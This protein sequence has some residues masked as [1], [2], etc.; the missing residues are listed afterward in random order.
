MRSATWVGPALVALL[1]AGS[2]QG[3]AQQLHLTLVASGLSSP[4]YVAATQSEPS[5]LYVVEKTGQIRVVDGGT[6]LPTPFL[7]VSALIATDDERGL[8][9]MAFSPSYGKNH[10]FYVYYTAANGDVEVVQYKSKHKQALPG[11]AHVVLEVPHP[12]S[13]HNGGQLQFGPDGQLYAGTGDGG[14]AGDPDDNAQNLSSKLGKLLRWN[15]KNG[16]WSLAGYGLRN[17][18]R[19]SFDRK[20]GDLWIGDVGQD[21]W[22]EIDFRR[23][24]AQP[25]NFG[26]SRYEGSHDYNTSVALAGSAPL[27]FPVAEY[28]HSD[29]CAVTGGYVYRGSAVPA[30]RGRYFYGDFCSGTI[31]SFP[32]GSPAS[33]RTEPFTLPNLSSF[34]EDAAGE[35]YLVSLSGEVYRLAG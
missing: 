5:R 18:W 28:S 10:L 2:A 27:V 26:W 12:N 31:W 29:G 23:A 22:E 7:D 21:S 14:G 16:T 1:L 34:G 30:A 6:L 13:N 20:T 33:V 4:T 17:P 15:P 24:G 35:L 9:S 11:S 32:A 3:R 8:L 25:A 19:F